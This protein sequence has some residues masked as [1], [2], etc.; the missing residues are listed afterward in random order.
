MLVIP[1]PLQGLEDQLDVLN[2]TICRQLAENEV[3]HSCTY[4]GHLSSKV[5]LVGLQYKSSMSQMILYIWDTVQQYHPCGGGSYDF[6]IVCCIN[7]YIFAIVQQF[8]YFHCFH[9]FYSFAN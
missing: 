6:I 3:H 9:I 8:K 1:A 7:Q 2:I 4:M 5:I